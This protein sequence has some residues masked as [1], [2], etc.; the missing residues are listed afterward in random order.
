MR[1][2][3]LFGEKDGMEAAEL[4]P[5]HRNITFSGHIRYKYGANH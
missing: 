3:L 5:K 1:Q 4:T 2:P